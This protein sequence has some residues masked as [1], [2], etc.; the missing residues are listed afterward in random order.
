MAAPER[1][2]LAG[3]DAENRRL[4]ARTL[5]GAAEVEGSGSGTAAGSGWS[6]MRC[7]TSSLT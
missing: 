5:E 2:T 1:V 3:D 7:R 6:P 4:L